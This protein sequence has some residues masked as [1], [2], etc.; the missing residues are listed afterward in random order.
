MTPNITEVVFTPENG[1]PKPLNSPLSSLIYSSDGPPM[2]PAPPNEPH[3]PR[4][5]RRPITVFI[6]IRDRNALRLTS[7]THGIPQSMMIRELLA[8]A[9][10]LMRDGQL[11][12]PIERLK[13]RLDQQRGNN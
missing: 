9:F 10:A 11:P 3:T 4:Q 12:R 8:D 7:N 2:T 13:K 5:I 6:D 1:N